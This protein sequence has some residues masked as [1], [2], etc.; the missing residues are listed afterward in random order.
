M[1]WAW[2][3]YGRKWAAELLDRITQPRVRDPWERG[4]ALGALTVLLVSDARIIEAGAL[5][6][7]EIH[8]FHP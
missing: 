2:P 7:L 1:E 3:Q 5:D 4:D 6:Q 8:A